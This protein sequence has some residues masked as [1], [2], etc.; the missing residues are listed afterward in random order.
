MAVP[1]RRRRRMKP[2]SG[3]IAASYAPGTYTTQIGYLAGC[4]PVVTL[5]RARCVHMYTSANRIRSV[6]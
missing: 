6:F 3:S 5:A 2:Q 1:R 4:V